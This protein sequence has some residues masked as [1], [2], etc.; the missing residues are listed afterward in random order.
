MSYKHHLLLI[1][2]GVSG[3]GPVGT[4]DLLR[5]DCYLPLGTMFTVSVP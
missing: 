5:L 3:E 1:K 4:R 2:R